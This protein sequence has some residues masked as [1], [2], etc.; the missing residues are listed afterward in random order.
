MKIG[1]LTHSVPGHLHPFTALARRV[2]ARGHNVAM[3]GFLDGEPLVRAA[4]LPFIPFCEQEHPAG[5]IREIVDQL[6]KLK[7]QEAV[8]FTFNAF[9]QFL[10]AELKHLPRVIKENHIDAL[11]IDES[12]EG[13]ELVP[14]HMGI[15]Y[16]HYSASM[17]YD[18]TGNTPLCIFG[19]PHED[20]PEALAR[21][22]E[23]VK[24]FAA[25]RAPLL[26]VIRAY[27][28]QA[29]LK[30]YWD[31]PFARIS[32]LAWLTQTP[33]EFDFK[34]SHWPSQFH[35]T[36]PAHDGLGR[37]ES[38][39]PWDRLTGEPLIYASM[40]TLQNGLE[41]V[42]TT[43]AEAVGERPGT[44]IVM[45]V[46]PILEVA[47]IKSL[48]KNAIVVNHAP[49]IDLLKRST[50][51]ITHAGLNTT[52]ES[53][54][55]GVPML[56]IPVTNDQPGVAAR[57]VYSKTGLALPL[58]ELTTPKLSSLIDEV[59]ADGIYRENAQAMKRAIAKTNG[60]EKAVD[61][62]EE[63]FQLTRETVAR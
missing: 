3:I 56:A 52:L 21:N 59:L 37:I 24:N 16:V 27:A 25:M 53:L 8:E 62:L 19:W 40:G 12:H 29:G 44:Q 50:L 55:Q 60:L 38:D 49:Q 43:I 5:A 31:D 47:Q 18:F 10:D 39:F 33:K 14:M 61:L 28:H 4:K 36:G 20:T 23:G 35:Y 45:S 7:G 42:F 57:I 30:L 9:A 26:E 22:K 41:P 54:A 15:P 51:C 63:A 17:H 13:L 34:S 6:S 32:K 58:P 46:G 2:Q 1:F 11:V 48:P